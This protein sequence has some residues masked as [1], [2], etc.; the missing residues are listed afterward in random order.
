M[1]RSATYVESLFIRG[2]ENSLLYRSSPTT[3]NMLALF[4]K[5]LASLSSSGKVP[6][7]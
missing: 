2:L 1:A 6:S 7:W 3:V 4:L 5:S